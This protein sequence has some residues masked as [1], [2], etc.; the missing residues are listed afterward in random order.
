[1]AIGNATGTCFKKRKSWKLYWTPQYQAVL[2]AMIAAGAEPSNYDKLRQAR[3][4]R[5][6]VNE[7]YFAKA[8]FLDIFATQI[9]GG[10]INWKSPGTHNPELISTPQ[11]EPYGGYRGSNLNA[12]DLKFIPSIDSTLT[13][14]N[15]VCEIIGIGDDRIDT[16]DDVGSNK[17]S[18]VGRISIRSAHNDG[19]AYF[20]C[21]SANYSTVANTNTIK[22]Y[23]VSRDA[24]NHYDIYLNKTKSVV[25]ITSDGVSDKTIVA[26]GSNENGTIRYNSRIVRYVCRFSFLT[27]L[28]V[29]RFI[30]IME[31][32]LSDY[33]TNLINYDAYICK[34]YPA[35]K[36]VL[37][38]TTYDAGGETVHP[39]VVDCGAAWNGYRYWMANTPYPASN[40]AYEN[41]SI[42][43]SNDGATWVVPAGLT[44]PIVAK[45]AGVGAYN[46]DPDL[47]FDN[48]KLYVIW[49]EFASTF[50]GVK[51]SSSEDG[52]TW[53]EPSVVYTCIAPLTQATS[54]SLIKIGSI[55]YIYYRD[56]SDSN[57][58]KRISCGTVNGTYAN[59]EVVDLPTIGF[60]DY[61]YYHFDIHFYN[62]V[63]YFVCTKGSAAQGNGGVVEIFKS[64]NGLNSF[65]RCP[66]AVAN[67]SYPTLNITTYYRPCIAT[68]GNQPVL[69]TS[70]YVSS[71]WSLVSMNI[72]L[73]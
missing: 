8:E 33:H 72:D 53:S 66:Y 1:M 49:N 25:N 55:Y 60:S 24:S 18:S 23:A 46:A 68:I 71:K 44:N 57:K 58:I 4:M 56:A 70:A 42:W 47:L 11:F 35:T 3:M 69:F 48:N 67:I 41:P 10:L 45:P 12:V 6:L 31:E 27:E 19:N 2:N 50:K 37:P 36:A 73:L 38:L 40:N 59:P 52:I 22:H 43:A 30:D 15:N 29:V 28:E 9:G 20:R 13:S 51:I 32:Y 14:Q 16:Q 54:C 7:G 39:S 17:A 61:V 34:P 63:Y 26:C 62:N 65:V 64:S 5:K 21:N